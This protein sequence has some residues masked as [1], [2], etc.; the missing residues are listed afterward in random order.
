MNRPTYFGKTSLKALK[1]VINSTP[2]FRWLKYGSIPIKI[3]GIK[4]GTMFR[5][6]DEIIKVLNIKQNTYGPLLI[7]A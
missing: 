6:K 1:G 4:N 2:M 3:A 7:C 5:S